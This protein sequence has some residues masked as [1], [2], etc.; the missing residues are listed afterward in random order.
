[1]GEMRNIYK[2]GG[3]QSEGKKEA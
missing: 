3:E 1:M 2:I